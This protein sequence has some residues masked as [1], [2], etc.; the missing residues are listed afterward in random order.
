MR[1]NAAAAPPP[2]PPHAPRSRSGLDASSQLSSLKRTTPHTSTRPRAHDVDADATARIMS[3]D[4]AKA[5]PNAG[6]SD[7]FKQFVELQAKYADATSQLK[8]LRNGVQM[9]EHE[10]QRARLTV[11]EME[12]VDDGVRL[13]KPLGRAF[14]VESKESLVKGLEDVSESCAKEIEKAASQREYLA[15]KLADVE[16]NL[17]ELMQGND[18][19]AAELKERGVI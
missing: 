12:T 3:S 14:V 5:S 11:K 7:G 15:K 17:R 18:A 19:L 1:E 6:P 9:R 13:F 4:T 10:R 16:T 2:P 8:N